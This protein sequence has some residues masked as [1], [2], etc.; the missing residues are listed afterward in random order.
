M[1]LLKKVFPFSFGAA[2]IANLII[3][4]LVYLVAGAVLGWIIGLIPLVG[5]LLAGLVGLYCTAGLIIAILD[6]L[7]VLK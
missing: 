2:D 4:I 3:K 6:Y 1:D 7:K 5:D